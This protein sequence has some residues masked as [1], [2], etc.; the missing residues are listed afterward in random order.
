MTIPFEP[1]ALGIRPVADPM[2]AYTRVAQLKGMQQENELRKLQMKEYELKAAE[3]QKQAQSQNALRELAMNSVR[4]GGSVTANTG[5]IN[6]GGM[7]LAGRDVTARGPA[8]F[9]RNAFVQGAYG[10][11]PMMAQQMQAQF[12][13]EDAANQERVL[14]IRKATMDWDNAK[15][16]NFTKQT[17]MSAQLAFPL[18]EMEQQQASPEALQQKYNETLMTAK[19]AGLDVSKLPPQY[20]PGMAQQIMSLARDVNK[21][22][23]QPKTESV[24]QQQLTA[25]LKK[26][27]GKDAS[28]FLTWKARQSPMAMMSGG[29]NLTPEATAMAAQLYAQTGQLPAGF[30]RAPQVTSS[31]INKA[32]E[33]APDI[34]ANKISYGGKRST[35]TYFTSG[36]GGKQ[37][38]AFNT[39]ITHLDTLARLANDLNNSNTQV[40]NRASMAWKEQTGQAAPA[41]FAA[42][43]NA[44]SGEVAAALKA[45]GATDQEIAHVGATFN[46]VQSPAQL[47][48]AISTYRELLNSKA[49]QLKRQYESGMQGVPA[50]AGQQ[51]QQQSGRKWREVK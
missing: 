17:Q 12:A 25:W 37:L 26:N 38:T 48:G 30:A 45:S 2:E 24:E 1:I 43:V 49:E 40:F 22:F 36:A 10:I 8:T 5:A 20:Q 13:Q 6:V 14:K 44:M 7:E 35:T 11:D 9:D 3:A 47:Q 34:A 18:Y 16:E 23:E 41:N 29:I 42:A 21:A 46:K 27:P 28:D 50:F 19:N 32:A 4:P 33:N 39:A 51:Q 15:L 31:V